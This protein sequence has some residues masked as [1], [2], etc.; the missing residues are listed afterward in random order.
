MQS[1]RRES[2]SLKEQGIILC[3]VH[4]RIVFMIYKT[5]DFIFI[6]NFAYWH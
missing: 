3:I 4:N 1:E 5:N 6:L 2:D